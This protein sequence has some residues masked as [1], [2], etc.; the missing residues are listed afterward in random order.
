MCVFV[1]VC[2]CEGGDVGV[3]EYVCVCVS[4]YAIVAVSSRVWEALVPVY[5]Q[6]S[7]GSTVI[8]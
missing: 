5:T 6:R 3:C 2:V 8:V 7:E 1:C 4:V